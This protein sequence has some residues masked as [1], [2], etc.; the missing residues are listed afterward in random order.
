MLE[1]ESGR[2]KLVGDR[3]AEEHLVTGVIVAALGL[4]SP[5][6]DFEVIDLCTAGLPPFAEEEVVGSDAMDVDME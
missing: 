6:G 1:D 4:E 5:T 2:I 3:V